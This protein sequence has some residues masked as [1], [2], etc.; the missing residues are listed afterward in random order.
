[1]ERDIAEETDPHY[2]LSTHQSIAVS[3]SRVG[4][5]E[6]A[7]EVSRHLVAGRQDVEAAGCPRCGAE[8]ELRAA[9]ALARI[10]RP[11]AA[12]DILQRA[13]PIAELRPTAIAMRRW[14]DGLSAVSSDDRIAFLHEA[15]ASIVALELRLEELW[16]RID[17]AR[18]VEER[19]VP[20]AIEGFRTVLKMA[21]AMGALTEQRLSDQELRR[22]GART[23]SRR[24]SLTRVQ[25]P[26]SDIST[27]SAREAEI[28]RSAAAGMSN[29]EI[30]ATLFLSRRT[31]EHHMSTI[32]RKLD[33]RNRTELA[34]LD[35]LRSRP[36]PPV[37]STD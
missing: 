29:P 4:R 26:I 22:L 21:M 18:A 27:L 20:A 35:A 1:M 16:L 23:W 36:G 31:V 2:R 10:G 8:F 15:L 12:R 13:S 34:G 32:L 33:L 17:L 5:H 37:D 6:K 7:E 30:A 3:L 19:D 24:P 9:E 14:I 25:G 28:A 11:Q